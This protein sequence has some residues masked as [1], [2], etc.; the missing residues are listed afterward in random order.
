[1]TPTCPS[2]LRR[3]ALGALLALAPLIACGGKDL[4]VGYD[5]T[6]IANV[7]PA[8]PVDMNAVRARCAAP[9]T[10][11][12]FDFSV[13]AATVLTGRWFLCEST[14]P[15][16]PAA[17]ELTADQAWFRLVANDSG[18]FTHDPAHAGVYETLKD[19]SCCYPD[20]LILQFDPIGLSA[21]GHYVTFRR[22]PRQML[23]APS[24]SNGNAPRPIVARFVQG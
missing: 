24:P 4:D 6:A 7:N 1:V 19:I 16:T 5:D 14:S 15:D 23:W 11:V 12:P 18:V 21:V 9:G 10:D 13:P 22:G 17:I 8:A 2:P 20:S 3:S